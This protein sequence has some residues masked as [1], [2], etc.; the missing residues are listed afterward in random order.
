MRNLQKE[1]EQMPE[2]VRD[3]SGIEP[4]S[5]H[6]CHAPQPEAPIVF[7]SA[8]HGTFTVCLVCGNDT[9]VILK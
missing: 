2:W 1:A 8:W 7:R 3:A 5:C 6:V 4:C 9:P